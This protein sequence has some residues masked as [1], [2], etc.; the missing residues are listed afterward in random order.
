MKTHPLALVRGLP[1]AVLACALPCAALA[2]DAAS[3]RTPEIVAKV[4]PAELR[5]SIDKLVSFGKRP[6]M[7]DTRSETR[8]IGAARRWVAARFAAISSDCGGCLTIATPAQTFT[9]TR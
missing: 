2:Q 8:G 1:F 5:A 9:D 3:A 4:D 6:T 7:S